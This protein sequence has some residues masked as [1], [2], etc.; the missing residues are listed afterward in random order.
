M[1]QAAGGHSSIPL[2]HAFRYFATALINL[3]SLALPIAYCHQ[4]EGK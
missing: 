1:I 2:K 4:V 3:H